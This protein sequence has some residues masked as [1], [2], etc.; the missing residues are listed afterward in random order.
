MKKVFLLFIAACLSVA[1]SAQKVYFVYLQTEDQSPFYVR[2]GDKIYSSASSGYLILPNLVD[3]TYYLSVGFA[4][5]IEP[6]AKFSVAVNQNDRGFLIKKFDDGLALF[7]FEELSV[8]KSNATPKDNTVYETKTDNFSNVLSKAA[9]DPSIVKV[10]VVKKEDPV[11]PK[12]EPEKKEETKPAGEVT[13]ESSNSTAPSTDV[14]QEAIKGGTVKTDVKTEVQ[15]KTDTVASLQQ[16]VKETTVQQ[17]PVSKEE[18]PV[19]E[20]VYKPSVVSRRSESSTTEGFGIVYL[21]R[22][23]E[24]TDTIRI[25]IPSSKIKLA[26]ET[27]SAPAVEMETVKEKTEPIAET[28]KPESS[29]AK[30]TA[31]RENISI[32]REESKT[33]CNNTASEKDFMKLRKKMAAKENDDE[34]ITEAK[35]EFRNKCYSVEQIRYLSTLFLTSAAKY[36]FFDAAYQH[37]SDSNNFAS[38]QSEIR[39]DYYLKRFKA[40]IGE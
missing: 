31:A 1:V 22:M 33:S 17:P 14:T 3:T 11:K 34:M 40:L 18:T 35:K 12:P 26:A 7:D 2:M 24:S 5:S 19:Q 16:G 13:V 28:R 36:Q 25:L 6:E 21:D 32:K 39:D 8:V 38:L 20:V 10:P 15:A 9:G 27:E 30:E 37:V 4:K 23:G 29:S